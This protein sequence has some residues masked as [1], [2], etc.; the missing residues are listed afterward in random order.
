M[1]KKLLVGDVSMSHRRLE[2]HPKNPWVALEA[3]TVI[4]AAAALHL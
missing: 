3:E 4:P 1:H 2:L